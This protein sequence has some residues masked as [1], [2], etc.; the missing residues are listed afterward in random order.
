MDL[1]GVA[2]SLILVPAG[3]VRSVRTAAAAA[4][5]GTMPET[6]SAAEVVRSVLGREEWH[7]HWGSWSSMVLE[8]G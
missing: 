7:D 1:M 4:A 2:D 6:L 8:S 5:A 3:G